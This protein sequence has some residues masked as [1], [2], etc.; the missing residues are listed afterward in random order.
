VRTK[1]AD[2]PAGALLDEP[3]DRE[4][5]EH[6]AEVGVDGLALVVVDRPGGQVVLGHAKRGFDREQPVVGADDELGGDGCAVGQ[7]ARLV[8]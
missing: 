4:R 1:P 6:D 8:R 5:G 3:A 2:R 7:V